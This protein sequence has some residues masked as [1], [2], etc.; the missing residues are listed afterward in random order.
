MTKQKSHVEVHSTQGLA[1]GTDG[2][3]QY[4]NS[5]ELGGSNIDY[6][7]SSETTTFPK[8]VRIKAGYKL[9]FDAS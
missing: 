2:Q 9:V 4:N 8:E 1:A 7:D 6:S 5:N 3:V